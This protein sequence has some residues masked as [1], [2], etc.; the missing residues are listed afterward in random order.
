VSAEDATV[1]LPVTKDDISR[2]SPA[3][4]DRAEIAR[5]LD[6]ADPA[7]LFAAA[8]G[9]D[10]AA[11]ALAGLHD[12]LRAKAEVLATDWDGAAAAACQFALRRVA[13]TA[14]QLSRYAEDLRA[15]LDAAAQAQQHA[16]RQLAAFRAHPTLLGG[17]EVGGTG[18]RLLTDDTADKELADSLDATARQWLQSVYD[19]YRTAMAALPDK[20]AFDLPGLSVPD[21]PAA[22]PGAAADPR[23]GHRAPT[24]PA[25]PGV[26]P[27]VDAAVPGAAPVDVPAAAE[28]AGVP[29]YAAASTD[30]ATG[31]GPGGWVPPNAAASGIPADPA[32]AS[33]G[34][35]TGP[36]GT[37]L[38]GGIAAT[39]IPLDPRQPDGGSWQGSGVPLSAVTD[40]PAAQPAVNHQGTQA[41]A[42]SVVG[43][44]AEAVAGAEQATHHAEPV[45]GGAP[46]VVPGMQAPA[47]QTVDAPYIAATVADAVAAA[48]QQH[49]PAAPAPGGVPGM[50][51][52]LPDPVPD[53]EPLPLPDLQNH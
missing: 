37:T 14:R 24:D 17:I 42:G 2:L 31:G 39:S 7:A 9:W 48:A 49:D 35:S 4:Y 25:A 21:L 46:A 8:T 20:V 51:G 16:Q 40:Q 19:G 36:V 23:T 6:A 27:Q 43:S 30:A 28:A 33:Y 11:G 22:A 50:Q 26:A 44:V 32:G 34:G 52:D 12:D 3:V 5:L 1:R 13:G 10:A 15:A 38:A 45:P 41:D 53:A 29:V 18:D 47:G